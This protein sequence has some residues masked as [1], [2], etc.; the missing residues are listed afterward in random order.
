[1]EAG[2]FKVKTRGTTTDVGTTT[3]VAI[4][5]QYAYLSERAEAFSYDDVTSLMYAILMLEYEMS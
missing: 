1:M 3:Y 4:F 2:S 5:I